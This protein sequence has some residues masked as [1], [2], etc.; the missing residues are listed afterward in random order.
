MSLFRL[1]IILPF[2]IGCS[3]SIFAQKQFTK[4]KILAQSDSS[5]IVHAHIVNLSSG[6]GV[7]SSNNGEF[8]IQSKPKDSLL[9]SFVG[10]H[11]VKVLS[12][13]TY[14]TV[15]LK[16]A[17]YSLEAYNVLPYKDFKEF[18]EAFT[19]LKIEDTTRYMINESIYL[20]VDELRSWSPPQNSIFRGQITALAS[21]FNKRIKDKKVYDKLIARDEHKAYLATKFNAKLIRQAT[22]LK[23][24]NKINAFME[25]CDFTD[26]FCN[27]S[28]GVFY[29]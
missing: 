6:Y 22:Y 27:G 23:K 29:S 13:N 28:G 4:G 15:Y 3:C 24:E 14:L 26:N 20:S 25:Y 10:Y 2:F 19:K 16:K 11:S 17:N 21:K 18:R 9:I 8:I 5:K 12:T 7:V 1:I